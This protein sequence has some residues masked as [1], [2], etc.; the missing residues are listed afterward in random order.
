MD[1]LETGR[2]AI[3]LYVQQNQNSSLPLYSYAVLGTCLFSKGEFFS[4]MRG[5]SKGDA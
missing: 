4:D 3:R 5:F 1:T 2:K